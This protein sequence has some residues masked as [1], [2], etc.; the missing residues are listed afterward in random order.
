MGSVVDRLKLVNVSTA[1]C[2]LDGYPTSFV[3]VRD[4]G[5]RIMLRP[6]HGTSIGVDDYSWAANLEP[7][8][9]ANFAIETRDICDPAGRTGPNPK[10]AFSGE[11]I[12]LPGGGSVRGSGAFNPSC[13]LTVT[14]IGA[15]VLSVT[16][17]NDYPGLTAAVRLPATVTAGATLHFTVT[18]TDTGATPVNLDPCPTYD[19]GV[20]PVRMGRPSTHIYQL[21]CD[22]VHS[23]AAGQSVTYAMQIDVPLATGIAKFGWSIF[24]SNAAAGTVITIE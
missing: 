14:P 18:L 21:N 22:S 10:D 15:P 7:G 5:N 1:S 13:G 2:T 16:D 20:Y 23:I 11:L 8:Q 24:N 19:E 9:A 6:D 12:G 17:I 4:D 3:G